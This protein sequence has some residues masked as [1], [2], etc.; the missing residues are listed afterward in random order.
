MKNIVEESYSKLINK[1]GSKEYKGIGTIHCVQPLDYSEIISR[2]ITL[3]RNKILIL[4]YLLL[5]II[6]KEELKLLMVLKIII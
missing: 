1:W 4:K 6:G 3:M 5:Q 2:V